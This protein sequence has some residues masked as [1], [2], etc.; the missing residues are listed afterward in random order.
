M[1]NNILFAGSLCSDKVF[2]HIF[3]T[4]KIRSGQSMQKFMSL[5]LSG[6]AQQKGVFIETI[7]SLPVA[8][9]VHQKK[10][11]S[12]PSD[13][14]KGIVFNYNLTFN[15][16]ILKNLFDFFISF[17]KVLLWRFSGNAK[18]KALVCDIL[19]L[20]TTA[21][22]FLAAKLS[23]IRA[24]AIITDM[25]GLDVIEGSFIHKLKSKAI[26]SLSFFDIKDE[27]SSIA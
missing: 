22:A 6:A 3:N 9:D 18:N 21:G 23:G 24:I 13:S 27:F 11:W 2:D 1:R 4:S 8:S 26:L 7:T 5:L 19:K 16:P 25:P 15:F 14:D 20:S 12:L 17:I 10:F